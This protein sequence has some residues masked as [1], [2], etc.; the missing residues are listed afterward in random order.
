MKTLTLALGAA[1]L[2]F[3]APSFAQCSKDTDCK[4]NRVC[5]NGQCVDLVQPTPAVVAPAPVVVQPA[6]VLVAPPP[7][8]VVQQPV[9]VVQQPPLQLQQPQ[10]GDRPKPKAGWAMASGIV[11]LVFTPIVLGLTAGSEATRRDLVPSLP[12]G[13]TALVLYIIMAPVVGSGGSSARR[14]FDLSGVVPL[15]V[16]A[17]IFYG[18]TIAGGVLTAALGILE[19]TPPEGLIIGMGAMASL[20]L[21]FLSIDSFVSAGQA[22]A[23]AHRIE[24]GQASRIEVQEYFGPIVMP[25]GSVGGTV[26]LVGRF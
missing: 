12:L 26:G 13:I 18:L 15:R 2:L 5:A 6:P 24:T 9:V 1:A 17:W 23:L 22:K 4:G 20:S 14:G 11:G 19:E 7:P 8:V 3:A 16:F 21:I 25:D 10:L